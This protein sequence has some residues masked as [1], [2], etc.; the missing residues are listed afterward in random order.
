MLCLLDEILE[1]PVGDVGIFERH[2]EALFGA[3]RELPF[4]LGE[5][6][7]EFLTEVGETF[8]DVGR[9]VAE[10]LFDLVPETHGR[11]LRHPLEHS[12]YACRLAIA[13]RLRDPC[14]SA[15]GGFPLRAFR[16]YSHF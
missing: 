5:G 14:G 15:L 12:H 11:M 6:I 7:V 16:L 3:C 8:L 2:V 13:T 10:H 4:L 9:F 1:P